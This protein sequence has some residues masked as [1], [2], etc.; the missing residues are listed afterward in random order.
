MVINNQLN[1]DIRL[2]KIDWRV[3]LSPETELI[4]KTI[5][6]ASSGLRRFQVRTFIQSIGPE[7]IQIFRIH[8]L[9]RPVAETA[10][11]ARKLLLFVYLFQNTETCFRD[12]IPL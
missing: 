2:L 11:F 10:T 12:R 4:G 7:F 1:K 5:F 6:P 8:S 3:Y 9:P